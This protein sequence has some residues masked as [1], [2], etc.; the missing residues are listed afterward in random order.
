MNQRFVIGV[1]VMR[2]RPSIVVPINHSN[3]LQQFVCSLLQIEADG[4]PVTLSKHCAGFKIPEAGDFF[5]W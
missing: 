1:M 5:Q 4:H 3:S 2:I